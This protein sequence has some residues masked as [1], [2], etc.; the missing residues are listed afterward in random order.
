MDDLFNFWEFGW[1]ESSGSDTNANLF[2]DEV[3]S[4]LCSSDDEEIP[5]ARHGLVIEPNHKE[6]T[7][8]QDF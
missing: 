8:Q 1:T 3:D 4:D 2:T 5:F 7:I 6:V